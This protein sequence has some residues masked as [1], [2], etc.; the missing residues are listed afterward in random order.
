MSQA[1]V[2]T[3]V[4]ARTTQDQ[5]ANNFVL[6]IVP[7]RFECIVGVS[8]IGGWIWDQ[9]RFCLFLQFA[10]GCT[11]RLFAFGLLSGTIS[12]VVTVLKLGEQ[13]VVFGSNVIEFFGLNAI[14]QLI[15]QIDHF[16]HDCVGVSDCF[17]H[18]GF[19]HFLSETF[20]HQDRLFAAR[21]DQ[22][23]F[24]FFELF[25]GWEGDEFSVNLGNANRSDW[26]LEWK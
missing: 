7:G 1:A 21:N 2:V 10:D 20:D 11:T 19:W 16:L 25:A 18:F 26:P 5:V 9:F 23:Q 4:R 14:G 15:D 13:A 24:A 12:I 6:Q 17:S 22:V 3:A 8:A